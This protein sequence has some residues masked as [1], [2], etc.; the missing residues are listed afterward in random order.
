MKWKKWEE[1][2]I[3]EFIDEDI[4]AKELQHLIPRRTV[5][6]IRAKLYRERHKR[7]YRRLLELERVVKSKKI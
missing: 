7:K 5:D 6:A 2:I 3:F 1:D 4:P